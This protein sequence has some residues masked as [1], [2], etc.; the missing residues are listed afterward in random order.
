[1][2]YLGV[3]FLILS[4]ILSMDAQPIEFK[5]AK[6]YGYAGHDYATA[7]AVDQ[8]GDLYVTGNFSYL[9]DLDPGPD[10][11]FLS[12][13]SQTGGLY[14]QKLAPDGSFKWALGIFRSI[15]EQGGATPSAIQV[16]KA[17]N[18]YVAGNFRG[19][20]DFN[21]GKGKYVR[22]TDQALGVQYGFLLKLDSLGKFQW[23]QLLGRSSSESRYHEMSID[24]S[25]NLIL[26]GMFSS[27]LDFD[28]GPGV[29]E[30]S[31]K[32]AGTSED[33]YFVQK[34][35]NTGGF[36]WAKAFVGS[37]SVGGEGMA[38]AVNK[39][40]EIYVAGL[41]GEKMY[42]NPG[43]DTI[44]VFSDGYSGFMTKLDENGEFQWAG[45]MPGDD[46]ATTN[47]SLSLDVWGNV[48]WSG[49]LGS[50]SSPI[51]LYFNKVRTEVNVAN[52]S[53]TFFTKIS[54]FG[55]H[56]WTRMNS[57]K[58][59]FNGSTGLDISTDRYGNIYVLGGHNTKY[60]DYDPG[61]LVEYGPELPYSGLYLQKLDSSGRLRWVKFFGGSS[62]KMLL[63]NESIYVAGA[64]R[65]TVDMDPTNNEY[66]AKVFDY[67]LFFQTDAFTL[68]LEQC[69]TVSTEKFSVCDSIQWINGITY[70]QSSQSHSFR[71]IDNQG[72][73]SM[74]KLDLTINSNSGEDIVTS[75]NPYKWID[76][77]TYQ[78]NNQT[79]TYTLTNRAG[80][81]SIVSLDLTINSSAST[82]TVDT[83]G[84]YQWIDGKSYTA[85]NQ[86]ATYVLPNSLG[87]DSTI[88]LNLAIRDVNVSTVT[89]DPKIEA[90]A[91]G[92]TYQW[93]DCKSGFASMLGD[94]FQTYTAFNNGEYAVAV[95]Q[96]GCIDTSTCV[97]IIAAVIGAHPLFNQVQLFPNPN[98]GLLNLHLG[99]LE[100]VDL[101]IYDIK[102]TVLLT[103][104]YQLGGNHQ[105]NVDL[106]PGVYVLELTTQGQKY[107][108][109]LIRN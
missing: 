31:D 89:D 25:G 109:E 101:A 8:A 65:D 34:L 13:P 104:N 54:S 63:N 81:D 98:E 99:D 2:K 74:I 72:C 6:T 1:M 49:S 58:D 90:K 86:N 41:M 53:N 56:I 97:K 59:I 20:V 23:V 66:I 42:L 60:T 51:S 22:Q 44:R 57:S 14:I 46:V 75:C 12:G 9:T 95:S 21:P 15:S 43:P 68:K 50:I 108:Y 40:N 3:F 88:T 64:F 4:S 19:K 48:Y 7:M 107:R 52:F 85:N 100:D 84:P 67:P 91:M 94:T 73:D 5:W 62:A 55:R 36:I 77:K 32:E 96:N 33:A 10:S 18:I 35:D 16:D 103:K 76:G 102:G 78:A 93:L 105:F 106:S 45:I 70:K 37:P 39:D 30:L 82:F 26:T 47:H 27:T 92:A 17:G 79:A 61:P 28:P 83:C 87:C 24:D 69:V 11:F 29:F 71:F 38:L 80:C